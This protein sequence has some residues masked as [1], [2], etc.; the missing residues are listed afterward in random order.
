[1]TA[2][3]GN[4]LQAGYLYALLD[5]EGELDSWNWSFFVP[6]DSVSPVG[7]S[8]TTFHVV[9][10]APSQWQFASQVNN[11]FASH[12]AVAIV[13]LANIAS[14][15][16][17]EVLVGQDALGQFFEMVEVP[18]T[19]PGAEF[20]S[21]VWFLNVVKLLHDTSVLACKNISGLEHELRKCAFDAMSGYLV[22][23][24]MHAL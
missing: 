4:T 24:G 8:G 21:R 15:G 2:V 9:S 19:D 6:D 17:Y 3:P 20:D 5:Y 22:H 23:Q 14:L 10:P 7:T 1:M 16:S 12:F 11:I 13:R 18:E